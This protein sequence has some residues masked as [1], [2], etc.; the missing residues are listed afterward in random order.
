MN[1]LSVWAYE[2]DSKP[3]QKRNVSFLE[4][5]NVNL[6]QGE[7]TD[8]DKF[9]LAM[10]VAIL[11]GEYLHMK[12]EHQKREIVLFTVGKNSYYNDL[13]KKIK[14]LSNNKVRGKIYL[15]VIPRNIGKEELLP[16]IKRYILRHDP[17]FV[18][19]DRYTSLVKLLYDKSI[20]NSQYRFTDEFCEL[21]HERTTAI[22]GAPNSFYCN[23]KF[24]KTDI[25][26]NHCGNAF[27]IYE[28]S[29]DFNIKCLDT[30]WESKH[31][32]KFNIYFK[33]QDNIFCRPAKGELEESFLRSELSIICN[34]PV[35]LTDIYR[36]YADFQEISITAARLH[37]QN[38][39]KKGIIEI[40]DNNMYEFC[41]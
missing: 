18:F 25:N 14:S 30:K 34:T 26:T 23:Y 36:K 29:G 5:G 10:F 15:Y 24:Y 28:N 12:Y 1:Y 16:Y 6:I 38:A 22:F 21:L 35:K 39:I 37:V 17:N 8:I 33:D 31:Q 4:G 9:Y 40:N 19:I 41:K 20:K 7:D 2:S 13:N 11:S 27:S 3:R 32:N